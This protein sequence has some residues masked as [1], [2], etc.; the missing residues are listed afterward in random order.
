MML[1]WQNSAAQ[2]IYCMVLHDHVNT[3]FTAASARLEVNLPDG[4]ELG[5]KR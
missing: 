5:H 2:S 1:A 3:V 4:Q